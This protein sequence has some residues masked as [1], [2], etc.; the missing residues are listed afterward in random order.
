MTKKKTKHMKKC[1]PTLAIKEVQIKTI[2]RCHLISVRMAILKNTNKKC[3]K[4]WWGGE[5]PSYTVDGNVN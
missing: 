3:G 1:S 4:G 2:L 5:E